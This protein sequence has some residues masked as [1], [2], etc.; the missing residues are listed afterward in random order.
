M[1]RLEYIHRIIHLF[2]FVYIPARK[3]LGI[4]NLFAWPGSPVKRGSYCKKKKERHHTGSSKN[5]Q[6]IVPGYFVIFWKIVLT[7]LCIYSWQDT[8]Q[9]TLALSLC[10]RNTSSLN[11][12]INSCHASSVTH[13]PA[14]TNNGHA[15]KS[16]ASP[17]VLL[18]ATL[19]CS[20]TTRNKSAI[21]L[22]LTDFQCVN[23]ANKKA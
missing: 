3:S 8:V 10:V 22:E 20:E 21:T 9:A 7:R 16:G 6:G 18:V 12:V 11:V 14:V 2:I 1:R 13:L 4:L 15:W 23:R 5:D 17:S 19:K